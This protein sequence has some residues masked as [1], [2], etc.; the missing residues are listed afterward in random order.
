MGTEE[1]RFD[2]T[3]LRCWSRL[4]VQKI[5]STEFLTNNKALI[6]TKY[7]DNTCFLILLLMTFFKNKEEINPH[8]V[9]YSFTN[10]A[11]FLKL[12]QPDGL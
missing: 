6:D 9:T 3:D 2:F 8:K 5:R 4:I 11:I 1:S 12:F 7:P 10:V